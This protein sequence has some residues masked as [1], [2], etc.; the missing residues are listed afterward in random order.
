MC[1][2]LPPPSCDHHPLSVGMRKVCQMPLICLP[3]ARACSCCPWCP[4]GRAWGCSPPF[5]SSALVMPH[6]WL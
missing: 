1:L 5:A 3:L 4:H 6:H 2:Q